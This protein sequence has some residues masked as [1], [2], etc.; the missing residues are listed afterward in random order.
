MIEIRNLKQNRF[1]YL[2][3]GAWDLSGI[4][5]LGFGI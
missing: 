3:I 4:W 5:N 2:D 1:G